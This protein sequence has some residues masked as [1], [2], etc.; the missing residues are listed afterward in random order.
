MGAGDPEPSL[1][2]LVDM[3]LHKGVVVDA[4]LVI[5][6]ADVDLLFVRLGAVVG[7][8]DR[9][10]DAAPARPKRRRKSRR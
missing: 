2:E 9:M 4:E 5:A 7:A 10:F 1:L 3:L 6:L 8:A